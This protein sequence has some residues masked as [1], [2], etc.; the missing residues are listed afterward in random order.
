[1]LA[2]MTPFTFQVPS[3]FPS[4]CPRPLFMSPVPAGYPSPTEA[5]VDRYVD[6]NE[7]VIRH[8]D[9]T[10]YVTAIGGSMTAAGI[11]EGDLLVVDRSIVDHAEGRIVI[12]ITPE[13]STIKRLAIVDGVPWLMPE[14]ADR[15]FR[16][17]RVDGDTLVWGVVTFVLKNMSEKGPP[18]DM[19]PGFDAN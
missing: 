5:D 3:E 14:T 1:M 13:G 10:F 11:D 15:S 16:A 8:P 9:A 12:A 4:S 6:L 19:P 2:G 7:R 17:R 18:R